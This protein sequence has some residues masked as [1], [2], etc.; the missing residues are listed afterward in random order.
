[1]DKKKKKGKGGNGT[2]ESLKKK[3]GRQNAD[4]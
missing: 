2:Q 1:M 4:G 3:V